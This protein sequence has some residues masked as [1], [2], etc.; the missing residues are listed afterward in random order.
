MGL[1][2]LVGTRPEVIKVASLVREAI[3]MRIPAKI[4][5][6]GQHQQLLRSLFDWFEVAPAWELNLMKNNQTLSDLSASIL[7]EVTKVI[8]AEKPSWLIVQG[9]TTSAAVGAYAA[10]LQKIPVA[11]IEA[12]LRTYDMHSPFPE[13][14]N[15]RW[16]AL[17]AQ[18][19]F[20][21]TQLSA[22]NLRKEM[23]PHAKIEVVGNTGIDSLLWSEHKIQVEE[24]GPSSEFYS[25]NQGQYVLVTLHRR[26]NFGECMRNLFLKIKEMAKKQDLEFFWPLHMNPNVRVLAE[27]IFGVPKDFNSEV[28]AQF[29]GVNFVA[30]LNYSEFIKAMVNCRFIITDSGGVQ[31]EAP[32]LGKPVLIARDNTERPEAVDQG[33][34][35]L[36]G[37]DMDFLE[38][39]CLE[40]SQNTE[41]FQNMSVR[42]FPYGNGKASEKIL[43]SLI[44]QA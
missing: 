40:L 30:P 33:S 39:M 10:F 15:R 29:G 38:T 37:N 27:E 25:E 6:T 44:N 31:E 7:G 3:K 19:A 18:A 36:I 21:P 43:Q 17:A 20:A 9:D 11:H 12:G 28:P 32:A 14:F 22:D 2:F 13:E 8:Q 35:V 26:E 41:T 5:S 34:A 24:T 42:R 4:L 23:L 16:I 1:I